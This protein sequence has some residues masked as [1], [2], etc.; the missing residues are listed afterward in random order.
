MNTRK[1]QIKNV[2]THIAGN[3]KNP[4]KVIILL[5]GRGGS[6]KDMM[7]LVKHFYN[8]KNLYVAPSAPNRQWYPE[9][10]LQP[11][12]TNQPHLNKSLQIVNDYVK[13]YFSKS[14]YENLYL[15]GFSQGACLSTQYVASNPR[16]YGG[17]FALSGGLIGRE[18]PSF[19]GDLQNTLVFL[20]CSNVD[21]YIPK[22]RVDE[23]AKIMKSLNANVDK[24]IYPGM[25]HTINQEELDEM[26]KHIC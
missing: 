11:I 18:I 12:S 8:E 13:K 2:E 1:E 15:V 26:K 17:V 7:N 25:A 6:G 22:G 14:G 20:G 5:H 4:Q 10:F 16:K 19:S 3:E 21:R 9:S 24:R 23:T